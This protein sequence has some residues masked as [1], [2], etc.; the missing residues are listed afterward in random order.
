M[1]YI[2]FGI[3]ICAHRI[4]NVAGIIPETR[5]RADYIISLACIYDAFT[6]SFRC[7]WPYALVV[8]IT[9]VAHM[10]LKAAHLHECALVIACMR[11]TEIL[12][13]N[14]SGATIHAV[15]CVA[16]GEYAKCYVQHFSGK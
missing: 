10:A 5:D 9:T 3:M 12:L 4:E 15:V 13:R 1:I 16:A 11:T 8:L 2:A 6:L 7:I 14:D